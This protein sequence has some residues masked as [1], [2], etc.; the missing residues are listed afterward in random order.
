MN[1]WIFVYYGRKPNVFLHSMRVRKLQ[2]DKCVECSGNSW[3]WAR[4]LRLQR[5]D[6]VDGGGSGVCSTWFDR[7]ITLPNNKVG[8]S[9]MTVWV[10]MAGPPSI[11]FSA[12]VPTTSMRWR[13]MYNGRQSCSDS[14]LTRMQTGSRH[15]CIAGELGTPILTPQQRKLPGHLTSYRGTFPAV[16]RLSVSNV[17]RP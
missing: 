15:R 10:V 6:S 7:R 5:C 13:R 4:C 1:E 12:V 3:V 11:F 17:T 8:F 2:S 14:R 16:R 9:S